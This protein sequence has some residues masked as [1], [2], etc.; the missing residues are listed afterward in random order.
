MSLFMFLYNRGPAKRPPDFVIGS[1]EQ[2]YLLRWWIIPRNR[3]FNIFLH[4]FLRSDDDRALHC[5]PWINFSY[6]LDGEYTEHTIAPGGVHHRE[7]M[8]AGD[9]RFRRTG[10]MAHRIELHNGSCWTLFITGPR[11]REWGF[12][13]PNGWRHWKEFTAPN[14]KGQIGKGCND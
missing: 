1:P 4:R 13:C 9:W 3:F 5:H 12:H 8:R 14:N 10:K 2:R 7:I 11:Y 6:L